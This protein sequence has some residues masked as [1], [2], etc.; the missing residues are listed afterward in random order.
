MHFEHAAAEIVSS[1]LNQCQTS[2]PGI[3]HNHYQLP[4]RQVRKTEHCK[5]EID[6]NKLIYF[7]GCKGTE[8]EDVLLSS[9]HAC[10][11]VGITRTKIRIMYK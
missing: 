9:H 10:V 3:C 8:S 4:Y 7:R 6:V 2:A 1:A 5:F 11:W